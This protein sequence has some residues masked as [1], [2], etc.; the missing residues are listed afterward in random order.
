MLLEAFDGARRPRILTV[1]D[2]IA[3]VRGNDRL[4]NLRSH[5]RV[6]VAPKTAAG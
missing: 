2:R 4:H 1:P 5:R 6:V 3:V